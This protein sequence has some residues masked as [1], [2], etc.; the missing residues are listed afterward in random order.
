MGP[1]TKADESVESPTSVL[2]DE[3][4]HPFSSEAF[5]PFRFHLQ[6][7]FTLLRKW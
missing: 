4:C 2:E 6:I 5:A 7:L 3:V 1:E